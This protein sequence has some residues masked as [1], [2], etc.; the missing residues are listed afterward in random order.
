ME[1]MRWYNPTTR[2]MEDTNVPVNDQQ[3]LDKLSHDEDSHE[4]IA[5]YQDW[6]VLG[7][8]IREAL[9]LTGEHYR[10]AHARRKPPL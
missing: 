2:K 10:A 5:H 1:M 9:L 4:F 3:A 6:R 7:S 8:S